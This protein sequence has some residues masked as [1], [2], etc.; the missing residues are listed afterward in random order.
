MPA[1]KSAN[2]GKGAKFTVVVMRE[3]IKSE[4]GVYKVT[5]VKNGVRDWK[6]VSLFN[7][8]EGP[9]NTMPTS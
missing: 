7:C 3:K 2:T 8:G 4:N 9:L 5:K 6:G 1:R